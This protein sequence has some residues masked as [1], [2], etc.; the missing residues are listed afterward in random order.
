MREGKASGPGGESRAARVDYVG[1]HLLPNAA[2][3][4]RLLAKQA[5]GELSRTEA[6]VL[7]TLTAAPRRVTE[8]AELEGLAQPTMTLVV[9]RLEQR[10]WV[11]RERHADDGRVSL[12][13]L[14]DRGRAQFDD[15][16][17]QVAGVLRVHVDAMSDEQLAALETAADALGALVSRVQGSS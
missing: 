4:T 9:Q 17:D 6:G 15:F 7:N 11:R 14:T 13:S 1:R 8:L 12:V 10:G 5:G 2:S 16:V 3:L